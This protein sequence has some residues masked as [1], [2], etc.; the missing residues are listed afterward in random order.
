MKP[1]LLIIG[2]TGFVGSNWARSAERAFDVWRGSRH[3]GDAPQAVAIDI[4]DERS[5]TAAFERVRPEFVTL[6]AALSDIDRCQREPQLAERIN[7]GG[8]TNVA[9]HCARTGARLLYTS[10]D[11]VFDGTRGLYREDDPPTP[12]NR[13]GETKVWAERAIA[14]LVPTATIARLSLV[15]GTSALAGGNSYLEKV[16]GNLRAGNEIIS[17][18]YELR[19][20]IDVA[21]LCEF[22]F[23]LTQHDR[24]AGIVHIGASDKISRYELARAIARGLGADE[25]LIVPQD[26]P[27]PGRAPR[28]CDD[29]LATD[30]LRALCRTPVPTCAQVLERALARFATP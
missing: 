13:Y 21:T 7:L 14:E 9:R 4:V 12:P 25:R 15:L 26:A 20:P 19:N 5:V 16:A 8:A 11:A 22:L 28:G 18:T 23:E 10:T 27:V 1:R 3:A 30:R 24:A 17:P 6:L 29:F 2:A